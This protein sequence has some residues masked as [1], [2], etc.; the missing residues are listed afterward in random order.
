MSDG[1]NQQWVWRIKGMGGVL[2]MLET[3]AKTGCPINRHR[4]QD[5]T[6]VLQRLKLLVEQLD[7]KAVDTGDDDSDPV[8]TCPQCNAEFVSDEKLIS[9]YMTPGSSLGAAMQSLYEDMERVR[10]AVMQHKVSTTQEQ[11]EEN[12]GCGH[13]QLVS[14]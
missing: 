3:L 11:S 7:G 12:G 9:D 2:N 14:E 10:S 1:S 8:L 6:G 5:L 13:D 4:I